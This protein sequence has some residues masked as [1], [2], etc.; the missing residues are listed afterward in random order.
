MGSSTWS[1]GRGLIIGTWGS[2]GEGLD[3]AG[4]GAAT[5]ISDAVQRAVR[6]PYGYSLWGTFE[7]SGNHGSSGF[8]LQNLIS[9]RRCV[10]DTFWEA[11]GGLR[12]FGQRTNPVLGSQ[13]SIRP[14][15]NRFVGLGWA[16]LRIAPVGA[17]RIGRLEPDWC[18]PSQPLRLPH[19]PQPHSTSHASTTRHASLPQRIS[20]AL[21]HTSS[22]HAPVLA[23][24]GWCTQLQ[25]M[26]TTTTLPGL[27]LLK[28]VWKMGGRGYW[29]G[30]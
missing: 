10:L 26:S 11:F 30:H 20:H 23:T 3:R 21:I 15:Q 1:T 22:R 17:P 14:D 27:M 9:V 19:T 12:I 29:L 24:L 7:G 4:F 8:L 13:P 28:Y 16:G 25:T 2:C 5:R 18:Q 6:A